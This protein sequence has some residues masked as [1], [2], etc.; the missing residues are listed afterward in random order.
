MRSTVAEQN[1]VGETVGETVGS[2]VVGDAVG[3]SVGEKVKL[4]QVQGHRAW[5]SSSNSHGPGLL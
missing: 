3:A 4:Q 2:E 5:T 1:L